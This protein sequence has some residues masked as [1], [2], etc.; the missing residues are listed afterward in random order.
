MSISSIQNVIPLSSLSFIL[1]GKTF[2]YVVAAA[3]G[4]FS[5]SKRSFSDAGS[6]SGLSTQKVISN[7]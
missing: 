4:N 2:S 7:K 5:L 3:E 1:T 6:G